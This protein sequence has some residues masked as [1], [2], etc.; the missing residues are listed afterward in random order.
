MLK[1]SKVSDFRLVLRLYGE[2]LIYYKYLGELKPIFKVVKNG[3]DSFSKYTLSW[4]IPSEDVFKNGFFKEYPG[5]EISKFQNLYGV[6]DN[7]E[8]IMGLISFSKTFYVDFPSTEEFPTVGE[9]IRMLEIKVPFETPRHYVFSMD[10]PTFNGNKPS[11]KNFNDWVDR[12]T[13]LTL[14]N[15]FKIFEIPYKYEFRYQE[16]HPVIIWN[17]LGYILM[18]ETRKVTMLEEVD[19]ENAEVHYIPFTS[20][21]GLRARDG[22]STKM[23]FI[24]DKFQGG[25]TWIEYEIL[26]WM[27]TLNIVA[28]HQNYKIYPNDF[29][30][31]NFLLNHFIGRDSNLGFIDTDK[32]VETIIS[33]IEEKCFTEN[34]DAVKNLGVEEA[35]VGFYSNL[36]IFILNMDTGRVRCQPL[37]DYTLIPNCGYHILAIDDPIWRITM[38]NNN[39]YYGYKIN[40]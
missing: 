21:L 39:I 6:N 30:N 8:E 24:K 37:E 15:I 7:L 16:G 14:E 18:T 2:V 5:R 9:L 10:K 28:R 13:F 33:E 19:R 20:I 29:H 1:E 17:Y 40:L 3:K 38:Y 4:F 11:M 36:G 31:F 35:I 22:I 34:R 12:D 27:K 32:D 26:D 23:E 25:T